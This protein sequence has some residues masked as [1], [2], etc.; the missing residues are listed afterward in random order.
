MRPSSVFIV[1][2]SC[3]CSSHWPLQVNGSNIGENLADFVWNLIGAISRI[4]HGHDDAVDLD[5]P[6]DPSV[7][8]DPRFLYATLYRFD[9]LFRLYN[10]FPREKE[11]NIY[12]TLVIPSRVQF[13]RLT[14][15]P[16]ICGIQFNFIFKGTC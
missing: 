10:N 14:W 16:S 8:D 5:E 6:N 13:L 11:M 12:G 9:L 7:L 4:R 1:F 2:L 15:K 3:S